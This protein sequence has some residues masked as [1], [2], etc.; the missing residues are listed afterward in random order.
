MVSRMLWLSV[1]TVVC[2]DGGSPGRPHGWCSVLK[3][4][5]C[6]VQ[7]EVGG[8]VK[9]A[10]TLPSRIACRQVSILVCSVVVVELLMVRHRTLMSAAAMKWSMWVCRSPCRRGPVCSAS[11]YIK[12]CR[13]VGIG[14]GAVVYG[15]V[16]SAGRWTVVSKSAYCRLT[17][18]GVTCCRGSLGP[19]SAMGA[20]SACF[21]WK[22][23][24]VLAVRVLCISASCC[25]SWSGVS[26]VGAS[27]CCQAGQ[28]RAVPLRCVISRSLVW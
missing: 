7:L 26:G 16:V 17:R 2:C 14:V 23:A 28:Q 20:R 3:F 11:T 10:H 5:I 8:A 1:S 15:V 12:E 13:I 4:G 9:R 19:G 18:C 24:L 22:P 6:G 27:S 21:L 25:V